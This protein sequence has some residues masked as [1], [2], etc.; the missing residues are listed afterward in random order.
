[1][2]FIVSRPKKI[3]NDAVS[4]DPF[5]LVFV[6]DYFVPLPE[7]QHKDV[8]DDEEI[9]TWFNGYKRCKAQKLQNKEEF[10]PIAWH[11][12]RINGWCITKGEKKR[13][14]EMLTQVN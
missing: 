8:D 6:L 10:M 13:I 12:T 4:D 9:T 5:T 14:K 11:S 2:S 1:M 7:M 3:Y